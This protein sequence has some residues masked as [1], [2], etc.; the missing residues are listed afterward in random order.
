MG[1]VEASKWI[2]HIKEWSVPLKAGVD[3]GASLF[4]DGVLPGVWLEVRL[5]VLLGTSDGV[6]S[7]DGDEAASLELLFSGE[8]ICGE[9]AAVRDSVI[10]ALS[11][12]GSGGEGRLANDVGKL[13]GER[14]GVTHEEEGSANGLSLDVFA[15][16]EVG[17][18]EGGVGDLGLDDFVS[19]RVEVGSGDDLG[20]TTSVHE[21]GGVGGTSGLL[22]DT[23]GGS[24]NSVEERSLYG[25]LVIGGKGHETIDLAPDTGEEGKCP[26]SGKTALRPG[27]D[28]HLGR[29]TAGI[30]DIDGVD[31]VLGVDLRVVEHEGR[32]RDPARVVTEHRGERDPTRVEGVTGGASTG[33]EEDGL[34]LGGGG[35]ILTGEASIEGG[36]WCFKGRVTARGETLDKRGGSCRRGES[37]KGSKGCGEL[38]DAMDRCTG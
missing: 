20:E 14:S 22:P 28:G 1:R 6:C 5:A 3:T 25:T 21:G 31:N 36:F 2:H 30:E 13:R 18:V 26:L 9:R 16:E 15:V 37:Q 11:L 7:C 12:A 17:R 19:G 27:D 34:G 35:A 4:A 23:L 29:A 24:A 38:H 32:G 33:D 8:R 10:A